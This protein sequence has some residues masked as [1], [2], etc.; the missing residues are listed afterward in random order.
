MKRIGSYFFCVVTALLFIGCSDPGDIT[1]PEDLNTDESID[2]K[3][4]TRIGSENLN[5]WSDG[6]CYKDKY[7]VSIYDETDKTSLFYIS[8][9]DNENAISL[10][11]NEEGKLLEVRGEGYCVDIIYNEKGY[12]ISWLDDEGQLRGEFVDSA[13]SSTK[14][15]DWLLNNGSDSLLDKVDFKVLGKCVNTLQYIM[16]ITDLIQ[17]VREK[18]IYKFVIDISKLSANIALDICLPAPISFVVSSL[19]FLI[20]ESNEIQDARYRKAMYSECEIEIEGIKESASGEVEVLVS[21]I[22]ANTIPSHLVRVGYPEPEDIT[23]NIVYWGVVGHFFVPYFNFYVEP[24]SYEELLDTTVSTTQRKS[25]TFEVPI[26]NNTSYIFRPYLKS[27]RLQN[28]I[29]SV[30]NSHVKYGNKYEYPGKK[31]KGIKVNNH[32]DKRFEYSSNGKLIKTIG[33]WGESYSWTDD[34]FIVTYMDMQEEWFETYHV[35][36]GLIQTRLFEGSFCNDL[37]YNEEGRLIEMIYNYYDG[38]DESKRSIKYE[39]E[40][41]RLETITA[42]QKWTVSYSYSGKTCKGHNP[43]Y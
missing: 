24:L 31:L 38:F 10:L 33:G 6:I 8:D 43:L 12:L 34:G 1:L 30:W 35:E 21:I 11:F 42:N 22:N 2:V 5:G 17:D 37:N 14:V 25:V 19:A 4:I 13:E 15:S 36:D 40:G 32:Y 9:T 23:R 28:W 26:Y 27:T 29:G 41:D 20:E 16:D 39:W 3:Q 7:I 18:D